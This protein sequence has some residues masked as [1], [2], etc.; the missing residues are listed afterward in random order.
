MASQ[1]VVQLWL[2]NILLILKASIFEPFDKFYPTNSID[3]TAKAAEET[4]AT[5]ATIT[6]LDIELIL[7]VKMVI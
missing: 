6:V 5:K 2:T 1:S 4:K 3:G 7:W